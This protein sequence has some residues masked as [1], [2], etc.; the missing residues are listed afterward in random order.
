[1]TDEI[2]NWHEYVIPEAAPIPLKASALLATHMC[3]DQGIG[4]CS[5]SPKDPTAASFPDGQVARVWH[6]RELLT[7]VL[8]PIPPKGTRVAAKATTGPQSPV[9]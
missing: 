2:R 9:A 7:D 1:M 8:S 5:Q 6:S 4:F 3:I